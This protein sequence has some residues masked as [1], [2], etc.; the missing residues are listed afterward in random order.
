MTGNEVR[1]IR[2]KLGMTRD[3]LAD[4]LAVHV[5]TV[6]RWESIKAEEC[7]AEGMAQRILGWLQEAAND[8]PAKGQPD[9]LI[10]RMQ[11][12]RDHWEGMDSLMLWLHG[13]RYRIGRR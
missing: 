6:F 3:Q 7:K 5:T 1:R 12:S 13:I 11:D 4:F 9:R 2:E 8:L 10:E